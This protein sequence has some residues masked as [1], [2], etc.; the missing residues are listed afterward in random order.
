L[1]KI[2]IAAIAAFM[3]INAS[4]AIASEDCAYVIPSGKSVGMKLYTDGLTV[5]ATQEVTDADGHNF[6]PAKNCG[7]RKG[8]IIYSAA[9]H[10]IESIDELAQAVNENPDGIEMEVRRGEDLMSV[11]A[12]PVLTSDGTEKLGLWVRDSTAGIGT[13][14]Y[15]MP[16]NNSY[17]ALG[18]GISDSD[19]GNILSVKSGNIQQC[20]LL[21]VEKS[22][23]GNPGEISGAFDGAE[24]GVIDKNTE[25]GVYG[26]ITDKALFG[27]MPIK[28]ASRYDV[29]EGGAYIMTD[30]AGNG[31]E[32]YSVELQKVKNDSTDTKGIVFKITD[33]R[34]INATGGVVRG[35]SG[36]PIIQNGEFVG[37]VTH[38][39]VNDPSR[40]YGILG[41]NMISESMRYTA[42]N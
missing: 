42:E 40:G 2:P 36:A 17:A 31:V 1:K 26:T 38:V 7:I 37:A 32:C 12:D 6:D 19:T 14:T 34:L 30:A 29:H 23:R 39:L 16:D 8:D 20:S 33:E 13:I 27:T 9:G 22:T 41:E 21:S 10:T 11:N 18:H 24:I 35:M 28:A 5:T 15:Y 3:L 4:A 25:A